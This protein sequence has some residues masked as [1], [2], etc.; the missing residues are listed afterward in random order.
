MPTN[1]ES[2]PGSMILLGTGLLG[3]GRAWKK[4]RGAQM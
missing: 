1:D 2:A 3:L 4:R